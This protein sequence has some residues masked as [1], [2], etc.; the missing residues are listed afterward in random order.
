LPQRIFVI[1]GAARRQARVRTEYCTG[2]RIATS[3]LTSNRA[4]AVTWLSRRAAISALIFAARR[5]FVSTSAASNPDIRK[6]VAGACLD[7]DALICSSCHSGSPVR[8][9]ADLRRLLATLQTLD[10][11]ADTIL[12]LLS[13]L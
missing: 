2:S 7:R 8:D 9:V 6:Y 11:R 13:N 10:Y 1:F 12:A 4:A 5:T 3:G